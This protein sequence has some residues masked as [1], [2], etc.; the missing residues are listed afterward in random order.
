MVVLA[1]L[2]F[3]G[4]A[5][6]RVGVDE[7]ALLAGDASLNIL[8]FTIL[9]LAFATASPC[10]PCCTSVYTFSASSAMLLSEPLLPFFSTDALYL[11]LAT[12]VR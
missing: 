1:L 2:A 5:A 9:L 7:R 6:A 3:N 12:E 8:D 4:V 11:W 10:S